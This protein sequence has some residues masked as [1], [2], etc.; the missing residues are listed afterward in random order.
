MIRCSLIKIFLDY[1]IF[2]N[3]VI[4]FQKVLTECLR[5]VTISSRIN[6]LAIKYI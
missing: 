1:E 4:W 5:A 2:E 3:F 6:D